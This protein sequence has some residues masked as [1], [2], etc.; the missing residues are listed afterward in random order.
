MS[1]PGE[2]PRPALGYALAVLA[3]A[4]W[5]ANGLLANW[6]FGPTGAAVWRVA[7][8]SGEMDARV[9]AAERVVVAFGIL[10]VLLALFRRGALRVI[11][12]DVPFVA[13]FGV[14]GLAAVQYTY[15]RT[16]EVTG[17]PTVAILLEYLSPVLVL[18]VSVALLGE[19]LTWALPVGVVLSVAGCALV[20]GAVG[21]EG[22]LAIP[23]E[24]LAW[25]LASAVFFGAYTLMG[26]RAAGRFDPWTILVWGLGAASLVWIVVLGPTAIAAPLSRPETA[27]AILFTAVLG[28]IVPFGAY[29]TALRHIA[30]TKANVT[31]ALE[32]AL[33]AVGEFAVFGHALTAIQ[34]FGGALVVAAIALVQRSGGDGLPPGE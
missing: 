6:L 3:A 28:T 4:C 12:R 30:A 32:P 29:L 1:V 21:G 33:V 15:Y 34:A 25:G 2:R 19:R 16:I 7:A 24:G 17:Q 27:V 23:P 11:P 9:L 5:A 10:V 13:I 14:V 20:V 31:A 26:R 22:R 8:A 18:V